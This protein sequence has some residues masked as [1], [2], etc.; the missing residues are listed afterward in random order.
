MTDHRAG[1]LFSQEDDLDYVLR[2]EELGYESL[3][4]AEGIGRSGFGKLERW[5]T[6]T[7]EVQ[8]A[9]GIVNIFSRSPSAIA[10][11]IA[12]LD[13][14]SNGRAILG[15]GV[16]SPGSVEGFH[17]IPFDRPL[18]RTREY[19]TLVRRY[20]SGSASPYRGE[21]YSPRRPA[22][23]GSFSPVRSEIPIFN[24]AL[25]PK[26]IRLTGE[27]ADGWLPNLFPLDRLE[28]AMTWLEEGAERA[29]RDV[30]DITV[31]MY[32]LTVIDEDPGLARRAA[33]RHIAKYLSNET[34]FYSSLARN[35]GFE[36]DVERV[37]AANSMDEATTHVSDEFLDLVAIAGTERQVR[38]RISTVRDAGVDLPIY[39]GPRLDA[40]H[41]DLSHDEHMF[42]MLAA[43]APN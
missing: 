35:A 25:G 39:R 29:G 14:H 16:A 33:A 12:T 34:G 41:G 42:R 36:T 3:W 21:F 5:A 43:L 8:L 13:D 20:L 26:N 11:E 9:T 15:V 40:V 24:A 32:I 38:R 10:Q 23:W 1:I 30:N 28:R 19:I 17:G 2:A 22:F 18:E 27:L 31:A 7:E 37:Q 6:V 4:A